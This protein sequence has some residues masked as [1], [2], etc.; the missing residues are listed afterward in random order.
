MALLLDFV[1]TAELL[2]SNLYFL[3][4]HIWPSQPVQSHGCIT[5]SA[6]LFT[7]ADLQGF[8]VTPQPLT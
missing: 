7:T 1:L 5:F 4:R 2:C 8:K 6:G 3:I